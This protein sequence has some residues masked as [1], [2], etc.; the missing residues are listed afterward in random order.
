MATLYNL[1]N[2]YNSE[3]KDRFLKENDFSKSQI[4]VYAGIFRKTF[5]QEN[6]LSK[7]IYQMTLTEIEKLLHLFRMRS[8]SSLRAY[9]TYLSIYVD[10]IKAEGLLPHQM[11][12]FADMISSKKDSLMKYVSNTAIQ[13][14]IISKD[15]LD[16]YIDELIL[17]EDYQGAT[18][19]YLSFLCIEISSDDDIESDSLT[20]IKRTDIDFE[21]RIINTKQRVVNFDELLLKSITTDE[22]LENAI[23]QKERI[24]LGDLD[25]PRRR[26]YMDTN[27]LMKNVSSGRN[28]ENSQIKYWTASRKLREICEFLNNAYLNF[29][30]INLSGIIHYMKSNFSENEYENIKTYE[31]LVDY[32]NLNIVALSLKYKTIPF[33]NK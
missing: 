5:V 11:N 30:Y 21:K 27:Y 14:Q 1:D 6:F 17:V 13:S 9:I 3:L 28:K 23:N 15:T 25:N 2:F 32:F 4:S 8:L 31:K 33:L 24:I 12:M 22:L 20:L 19:L 16:E 18:F 10:W 7:D 29:N 26:R